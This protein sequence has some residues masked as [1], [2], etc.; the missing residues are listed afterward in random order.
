MARKTLPINTII[1]K[2]NALLGDSE[3]S[4]DEREGIILFVDAL[5]IDAEAYRGFVPLS[6]TDSAL[7]RYNLLPEA[8]KRG[9]V[10]GGGTGFD[11]G[12]AADTDA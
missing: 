7:R 10:A 4:S 1:L 12:V 11:G 9:G 8:V 3:V 6:T 2:A 5:L